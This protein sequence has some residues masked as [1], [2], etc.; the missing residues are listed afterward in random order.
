MAITQDWAGETLVLTLDRPPVNAL[1]GAAI[2]AATA[3]FASAAARAPCGGV[4]LTGAGSCFCAGVDTR[5]FASLAGGERRRLAAAITRMNAALAGIGAPV[6]G[7]ANGHA[8]GGGLVLLLLCDVRLAAAE[9]ALRMAL[10]EAAAGVPFPAGPLEVVRT[11][12]P[13]ALAR[14]MILTSEA[15]T[16]VALVD[17][18]VL[19]GLAPAQALLPQAIAR[20]RAMA[21]QPA[22]A[23]VKAQMRGP[24]AQR[25]SALAQAGEAVE[26]E[27]FRA[28]DEEG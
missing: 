21:A 5:F 28:G 26:P 18:G 7:A 14:R 4:V 16:P 2:E 23:A 12:L 27:V 1:D 3:A 15:E 19:D 22:F 6:V 24:L 20:A 9:P 8:M 11:E 10:S 13:A 17:A 25:L